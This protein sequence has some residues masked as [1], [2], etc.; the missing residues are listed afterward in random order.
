MRQASLLCS[1]FS[2]RNGIHDP[3]KIL[4]CN[5]ISKIVSI[6]GHSDSKRQMACRGP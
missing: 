2:S 5:E 4:T 6:V 1:H 3:L